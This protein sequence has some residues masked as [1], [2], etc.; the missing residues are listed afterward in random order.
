M[1][2]AE[3]SP[4]LGDASLPDPVNAKK[5][6]RVRSTVTVD[7]RA[8]TC[9]GS[10]YDEPVASGWLYF[11]IISCVIGTSFSFGYSLGC[12]NTP[13]VV[14]QGVY[15]QWYNNTYHSDISSGE[16]TILWAVTV[17][18]YIFGGM[19]GG[20][21]GG[22]I[23][24]KFGRKRTMMV[25]NI[26]QIASTLLMFSSKW[27]QRYEV[28][29]VARLIYGFYGGVTTVATPLYLN[30]ISP[31]LLRGKIGTIHQLT[32]VVA[33]S[34]SQVLGLPQL[35]GSEQTFYYLLALPVVTGVLH[36]LMFA[37]CPESP[38]WLYLFKKD[39]EGSRAALEKLRD[40]DVMS[41]VD[42]ELAEYHKQEVQSSSESQVS[43]KT[44]FTSYRKRPLIIACVMQCSQ[45]LSGINA[46]V[47]YSTSIFV[48]ANLP[49]A[50]A[51]YA[52]LG[53]GGVMIIV[54]SISV[55]LIERLGRR[56][57]HLHGLGG[58]FVGLCFLTAFYV[59]EDLPELKWMSY[60]CIASVIW[61]IISFNIGPGSIPWF[62]TTEIT[63]P[64]AAKWTVSVA[65]FVNWLCNF[66]VG[67]T[68]PF[69]QAALEDYVFIPFLPIIAIS[70]AY[71]FFR[72]PETKGKTI[73]EIT[74]KFKSLDNISQLPVQE[75]KHYQSLT[76]PELLHQ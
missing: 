8:S 10:D 22:S 61:F 5:D 76:L 37:F 39:K 26:L 66:I 36:W 49:H 44:I 14:I 16:L 60:L 20:V 31:P 29:I 28:I 7:D 55:V 27:I 74:A 40:M 69:L 45:Q 63:E 54:T 30:E 46:V 15:S 67:V 70:S 25:G 4:L 42:F 51:Q 11:A 71:L 32:I 75:R 1:S 43:L 34:L 41:T 23:A 17:S 58:C 59:L 56:T 72:A 38:P 9:S 33:L 68:F 18:I 6:S 3:T 64:S 53:L 50:D 12:I 48:A 2:T 24:D 35:L 19:I 52:T 62:Y 13:A 65:T 73:L 47:F 21:V 57:L